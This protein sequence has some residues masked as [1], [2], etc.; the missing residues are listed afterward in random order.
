MKYACVFW[1]AKAHKVFGDPTGITLAEG[2]ARM[3]MAKKQAPGKDRI[4]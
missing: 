3:H 1:Y 4:R 2:I